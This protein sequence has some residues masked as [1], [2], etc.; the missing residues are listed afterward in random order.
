MIKQCRCGSGKLRRELRDAAGTFV[1]FVC[2]KCEASVKARYR[3]EIFTAGTAYAAS[4]EEHDIGY[5]RFDPDSLENWKRNA[6]HVDGLDR[7]DL[8][9]SPDY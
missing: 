5:A 4:G 7:D 9:E 6:D 1:S 8:G 2:D 3:P